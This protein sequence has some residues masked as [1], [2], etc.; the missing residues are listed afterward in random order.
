[1]SWDDWAAIEAAQRR[2]DDEAA[3]RRE[4]RGKPR[5]RVLTPEDAPGPAREAVQLPAP[6]PVAPKPPAPPVPAPKPRIDPVVA[7][8]LWLTTIRDVAEEQVTV[9]DD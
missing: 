8:R 9:D 2:V 1:M 5:L 3:E 6:A 7:F 4:M